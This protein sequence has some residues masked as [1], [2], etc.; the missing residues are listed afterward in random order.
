MSL[1]D[2][3]INN[4]NIDLYKKC[5]IYLIDNHRNMVNSPLSYKP[6]GS[7]GVNTTICDLYNEHLLYDNK[8]ML[9]GCRIENVNFTQQSKSLEI[10]LFDINKIRITPDYVIYDN[11]WKYSFDARNYA[12]T[13]GAYNILTSRVEF[14]K[15]WMNLVVN[16]EELIDEM[17]G[18]LKYKRYIYL[19]KTSMEIYSEYYKYKKSNAPYKPEIIKVDNF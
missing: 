9:I 14:A 5:L 10:K 4:G 18:D 13:I 17:N 12:G 2:C 8:D 1:L 16:V 15:S 6:Y 11:Q 3:D 7:F 19:P